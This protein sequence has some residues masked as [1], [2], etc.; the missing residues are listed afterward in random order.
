MGPRGRTRQEISELLGR[1]AEQAHH[2]E[3]YHDAAADP[4][5]LQG[6]AAQQAARDAAAMQLIEL[7]GCTE[8]FTVYGDAGT[9]LGRLDDTLARLRKVRTR[10]THPESGESPPPV[11][12]RF[13]GNVITQLKTAID[14]LDDQSLSRMPADQRSALHS[15]R[16]GLSQIEIDGLPNADA[17]RPRDLHYAGYY[18]EIQFGR[19]AKATGLYDNY[20]K[21]A[22]PREVDVNSSISD[23]DNFAHKFHAMRTGHDKSRLPVS[24]VAPDHS[25]RVSGRLL[26]EIMRELRRVRQTP[27]EQLKE[28]EKG[29]ETRALEE[30]QDAIRKLAE[31]Y[32][33]ITGDPKASEPVRSY[34]QGHEPSLERDA[35]DAIREALYI[36]AARDGSYMA[37]AEETRNRCLKL[38]FALHDAERDGR[39]IDILDAAELATQASAEAQPQAAGDPRLAA[40]PEADQQR[41]QANLSFAERY[42]LPPTGEAVLSREHGPEQEP[43]PEP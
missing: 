40:Q 6:Q 35:I 20:G 4:G 8:A 17:L 25:H 3:A 39:L 34:L 41:H 12:P 30:R 29:R 37:I 7:A 1:A 2:A 15:I 5:L 22:D 16:A 11:T 42:G 27:A 18:R 43:E 32:A 24:V 23:A 14:N 9:T 26:S 38:S 10:Q 13:L 33:D 21:A 31:T 19:L 36:A 28:I